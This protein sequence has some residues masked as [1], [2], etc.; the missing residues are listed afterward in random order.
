M[1]P[2]CDKLLSKLVPDLEKGRSNMQLNRRHKAILFLTLVFT[3]CALLVGAELK[4]AIGS[5]MLGV[6]L[7]WAIGSDTSSRFYFGLKTAP[8]FF[9]SWGR[10]PFVMALTGA[11]LGAVL[12]TFR[13]NPVA[14][15]AF[16]SAA[17]IFIAPFR[18]LPTKKLWLRIPLVILAGTAFF[19]SAIGISITEMAPEYGRRF[20]QLSGTG[21][22]V[23]LVGIFWLSKGWRL[24]EQGIGVA[25]P[26]QSAPEL[27][28]TRIWP[29]FI[30]LFLG[31]TLLTLWLSML[32]WLASSNWA[33][34]PHGIPTDKTSNNL[35]VQVV[36]V[37]LLALW[38]YKVWKHILSHE[39]NTDPRFLRRH[40][41]ITAIAGMLF[42][43]VLSLAITYGIQNGN[44]RL[45]VS[46]LTAAGKDLSAVETRIGAIKHRDMRTTG[47]YIQAYSEIDVLL[48]DLEAKI[49]NAAD[50]YK[51][52]HDRDASRGLINIQRFYKN[53]NPEIWK[54][55]EE[56]IGL[57]RQ[58]ESLTRQEVVTVR[59]MAALPTTSEQVN[60][61]QKKFRP[62][63]VEENDLTKEIRVVVAK[64]QSTT[65]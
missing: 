38:P 42:A 1:P 65:G 56:L 52:V 11:L 58:Y 19:A 53:N 3:G 27:K 60:F 39:P 16:M 26:V 51:E 47:D 4:E 61:W 12:L 48:P 15:V 21:F 5:M 49:Q 41:R 63:L 34:A 2:P 24:I 55:N 17:G 28:G 64:I 8:G 20:G 62:L 46:K 37:V 31:V 40:K 25:P 44:D 50:T 6:A 9:Y 14:V 54:D 29:R 23:L 10:L 43:C 35:L 45:L 57:L 32:G 13:A 33:Y 36:F 59:N 30:S 18:T 7:A 22:V